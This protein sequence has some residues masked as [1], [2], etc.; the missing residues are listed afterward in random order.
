MLSFVHFINLV[1]GSDMLARSRG[2]AES[3]L[4]LHVHSVILRIHVGES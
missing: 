2:L 1:E 4:E 3:I